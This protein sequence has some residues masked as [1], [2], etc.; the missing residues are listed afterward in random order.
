MISAINQEWLT[1]SKD[2]STGSPEEH[3]KRA[4]APT[5]WQSKGCRGLHCRHE[6]S[7]SGSSGAA[8]TSV[9]TWSS[10]KP[11]FERYGACVKKT[12]DGNGAI[13][14]E[15]DNTGKAYTGGVVV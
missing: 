15:C 12:L 2:E 5:G 10:L 11:L 1:I 6:V 14:T 13:P 4:I 7:G 9:P 8:R 3:C